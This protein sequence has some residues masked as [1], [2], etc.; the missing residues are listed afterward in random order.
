MKRLPGVLSIVAMATMLLAL[1]ACDPATIVSTP[2]PTASAT[3][4]PTSPPTPT[5]TPA[6]VPASVIVD[7][8][9][10]SVIDSAG[11]LMIDIPF[12]TNPATAVAQLNG[13]LGV[14]GVSTTLPATGCFHQR[15]Q[16]TWGG[17][18]FIW[19][20]DWQRAP[21]AQFLASVLGPE[22]TSGVE[23]TIPSGQ[24]VGSSQAD[25]L[26][27]NPGAHVDDF[28]AWI[29]LHYDIKSGVSGG[30]PDTYYGAYALID[31]GVLKSFAS[32]IH[33][34]YDC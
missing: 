34:D 5:P 22:S 12:S 25:T 13:A 8:D 2:A 17:L 24:M 32:P 14:D 7:G 27:G 21:G 10:V 18:S 6:A 33:Y 16:A 23:V 15:P 29:S 11:A 1:T 3:A 31:G 4:M 30:N 19:G 26:A 28:G 9:S 20:D